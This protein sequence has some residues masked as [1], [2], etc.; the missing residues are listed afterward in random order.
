VIF[1]ATLER[2]L[3]P[4]STALESLVVTVPGTVVELQI[5]APVAPGEPDAAVTLSVKVFETPDAVAVNRAFCIVLVFDADAV[6][7]ALDPPAGTVM[8]AGSDTTA[9]FDVREA[10]ICVPAF[11][12]SATVHVD[13]AP[14]AIDA[15]LQVSDEITGVL[16]GGVSESG[17]LTFAV[18]AD[19]VSVAVWLLVIPEMLAVK[20]AVV[21]PAGTET[22]AGTV[23]FELLLLTDTGK[24]DEGALPP[25]LTE[26]DAVP[27]D[28]TVPGLQVNPV[29][30]VV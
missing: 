23:T 7:V 2:N 11:P 25:R 3:T 6:N 22:L 20:D 30:V 29:S 10:V 28:C 19:A 9:L 26:Q 18:P 16:A 8:L 1:P 12:V 17:K 27:G 21:C 14:E 5:D 15:G 4:S 24:V 13:F